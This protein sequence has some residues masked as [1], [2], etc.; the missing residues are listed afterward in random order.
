MRRGGNP[1][2]LKAPW[3]SRDYMGN[4]WVFL[5]SLAFDEIILRYHRVGIDAVKAGT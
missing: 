5:I 3:R 4:S 1:G 2:F